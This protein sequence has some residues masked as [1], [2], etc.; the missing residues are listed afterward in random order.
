MYQVMV[1][2]HCG[3]LIRLIAPEW[4]GLRIIGTDDVLRVADQTNPRY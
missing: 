3:P 2:N 4:T 1:R